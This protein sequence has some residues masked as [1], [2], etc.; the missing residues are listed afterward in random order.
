MAV[1][2]ALCAS[3]IIAVDI[4]PSRLEFARSYAATEI[5]QPPPPKEGESKVVFAQRNA[6]NMKKELRIEDHGPL[7]IDL[8]IDARYS[9]H[10]PVVTF[11]S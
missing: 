2:K 1:A 5:Y 11:N 10:S 3:R 6:A 8:V 4:I 9:L 7:A